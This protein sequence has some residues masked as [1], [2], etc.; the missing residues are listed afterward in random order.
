MKPW[1]KSKTI[2]FNLATAGAV[3]LAGAVEQLRPLMT[4]E[5]FVLFS[6]GVGMVNV[7][8]RTITSEGISHSSEANS[9]ETRP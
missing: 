5:H 1:F 9:N 3:F 7:F 6:L 8:L 4:P 2:L